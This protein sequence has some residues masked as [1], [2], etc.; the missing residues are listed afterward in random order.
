MAKVARRSIH[1]VLGD[2]RRALHMSQEQFGYAVGSSH[3]SA[4][5]W[6][7]GQSTPA[8]HHLRKLAALL[9][10]ADRALAAEV[11]LAIDETLESLGLEAPPPPAPP[12]APALRPE[13]LIE[14]VVL[15]A[16]EHTGSTPAAAR[17]WLHAV[18]KRANQ[19]GLTMEVAE[20]ALRPRAS[21]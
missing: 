8:D 21:Q 9:Y 13:D 18:F 15:A 3:R 16:V 2:A 20:R 10:P 7:A 12:P 4:V 19:I 5:R 14:I 6:D 11:A 17:Q 1:L